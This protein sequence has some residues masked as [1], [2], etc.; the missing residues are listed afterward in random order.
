MAAVASSTVHASLSKHYPAQ[1]LSWVK[2]ATWTK[3]AAV[4]LSKIDMSRRPGGRDPQKTA[5]IAAAVKAGKPMPPVMLVDTGEDKYAIADG[6]HRTLGHLHAGKKTIPALVA[7]G[8]GKTGPWDKRMHA[9]KLNLTAE[10][11]C[12][13]DLAGV[14]TGPGP[15]VTT[16]FGA[17]NNWVNKA[18]GLPA[19]IRAVAHAFRRKGLSESESIRRAIG[20]IRNWAE[21]KGNVTAATRARAAAALAA[22][23]ALKAKARAT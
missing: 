4:P 12:S 8:V 6:Y 1:V 5:A 19:Y 11:T 14:C 15:C 17:G 16:S 21:G 3:H 20:V 7:H 2:R 10:H 13:I 23:D 18:G 9:A 22:W